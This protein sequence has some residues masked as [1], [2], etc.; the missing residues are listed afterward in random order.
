MFPQYNLSI[1]CV[2]G[3]VYGFICDDKVR[4]LNFLR[5]YDHE[6][7]TVSMVKRTDPKTFIDITEPEKIYAELGFQP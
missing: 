3:S 5:E 2:D 7:S 6:G 1:A 4:L